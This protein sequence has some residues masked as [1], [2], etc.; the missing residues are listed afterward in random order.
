MR[1]LNV[2]AE[3]GGRMYVKSQDGRKGTEEEKE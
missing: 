2:S 1:K 3:N